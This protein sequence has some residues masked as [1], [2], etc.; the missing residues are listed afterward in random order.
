M[1]LVKECELVKILF[2]PPNSRE[3]EQLRLVRPELELL[4]GQVVSI[5]LDSR[6]GTLLEET[7]FP[8]RRYED[9][10]TMNMVNIIKEEKPDLVITNPVTS[11]PLPDA[12][13]I[14][15]SHCGIPCLQIYNGKVIAPDLQYRKVSFQ[16]PVMTFIRRLGRT[17]T[18]MAVLRSVLCLMITLKATKS[19]LQLIGRLPAEFLKLAYPQGRSHRYREGASLIVPS[20]PAREAFINLGWPPDS[21]F[22]AG[23]PRLDSIFH[24]DFD[25]DKLLATLGIPENKNIA[26]LT[27]QLLQEFW[28]WQDRKEFIAAIATAMDSFPDEELVIKLHPEESVEDY[29]RLLREIGRENVIVCKDI[30]IYDLL[31][32]CSFMMTTHS[33]TALEAMMFDKPVLCVDFTGKAPIEFYTDDGAALGVKKKDELVP[34]IDRVLH[35]RNT[36]QELKKAREVFLSKHIHKPDGKTS[37]RIAELIIDLIQESKTKVRKS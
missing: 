7:G 30:S 1:S 15:A 29:R 35:D 24:Q 31:N 12:F 6:L 10:K 3:I 13:A 2:V 33:T 37:K 18:S 32:A 26:L 22:V 27:T 28:T 21:V 23:Q 20:S 19:P 36:R 25:K 11:L 14:A 9:Y 8:F 34:M 16:K 17:L 4:G 5:A